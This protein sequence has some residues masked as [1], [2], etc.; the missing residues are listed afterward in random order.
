MVERER[1]RE[2]RSARKNNGLRNRGFLVTL[3]SSKLEVVSL[4]D[5]R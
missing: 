1:E 2:I 5:T 4:V 3:K